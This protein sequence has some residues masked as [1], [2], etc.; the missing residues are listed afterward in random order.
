M[1][2]LSRVEL[3][4]TGCK[5]V[6]LPLA[7]QAHLKI[8]HQYIVFVKSKNKKLDD[9]DLRIYEDFTGRSI[10]QSSPT[11]LCAQKP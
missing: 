11:A 7:P 3:E 4:I 1:V 8:L 2:D 10:F 6:V 5:P 9:R